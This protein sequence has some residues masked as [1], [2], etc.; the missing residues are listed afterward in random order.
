MK[1]IT[2]E[3]YLKDGCD[4]HLRGGSGGQQT[5]LFYIFLFCPEMFLEVWGGQG[6]SL[7]VQKALFFIVYIFKTCFLYK[8][9]K[10]VPEMV[11]KRA[12]RSL[13]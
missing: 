7:E 11:T 8:N 6:R 10:L 5:C 2:K 1:R 3:D 9:S 12:P 4:R 13:F